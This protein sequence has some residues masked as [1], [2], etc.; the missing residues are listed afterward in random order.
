ML[1]STVTT[2]LAN[3]GQCR[4]HATR[5]CRCV[6]SCHCCGELRE[7]GTWASGVGCAGSDFDTR[8]SSGQRI[9]SFLRQQSSPCPRGQISQCWNAGTEE[10][11]I[12]VTCPEALV[13][14][15]AMVFHKVLRL[16]VAH[17]SI[18]CEVGPILLLHDG[19]LLGQNR[20]RARCTPIDTLFMLRAD[21]PFCWQPFL[22]LFLW[23]HAY[24]HFVEIL[25]QQP[26]WEVRGRRRAELESRLLCA[27]CLSMCVPQCTVV[28]GL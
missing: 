3:T 7:T 28:A 10:A 23:Y 17:D 24:S 20:W 16:F 15:S 4:P 18:K 25:A 12:S 8:A 14:L 5:I 1:L 11:M 22:R 13:R 21:Q 19:R 9:R 2:G 27:L 6:R 26:L